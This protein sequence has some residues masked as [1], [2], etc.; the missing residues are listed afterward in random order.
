MRDCIANYNKLN[1][2]MQW[3]GSGGNRDAKHH[4][5]IKTS[6][7]RLVAKY[8]N[9]TF[10]IVED[11]PG[12]GFYLYVYDNQNKCIK[13]YLQ[14]TEQIIKEFAFEEFGIPLNSWTEYFSVMCCFCGDSLP[15][16]KSVQLSI[17]I[18]TDSN[19]ESQ[20]IFSHK[21]C[22]DTVLHKSVVR[23]PDLLGY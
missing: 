12:I 13:D 21:Q 10:E 8:N 17:F 9:Q 14:A 4:L 1:H 20:S 2:T 5:K 19:E 7:M 18:D 3:C 23:H 16:D 15:M 11:K 6:E 22:L